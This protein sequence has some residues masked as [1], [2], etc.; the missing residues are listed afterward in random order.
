MARTEGDYL[1]A[2]SFYE[3]SLAIRRELGDER[4]I[5]VSLHNLGFVATYRGD[6]RQAAAFFEESL[7][8]FQKL[9]SKRGIFC[10]LEG[11]AGVAGGKGQSERAGRLIGAVE[12]LY[13]AFH[14]RLDYVDQIQ[15][16]RNVAAVRAQLDEATFAAVW[17]EGRAM[18]L[19]QAVDYA[20]AD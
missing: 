4:G 17:A 7:P 1:E 19:E 16:D 18:T 3:E 12:A 20:L 6:Y 8:L 9:G 14:M 10:S 15:H 2:R 13:A 5:G 11:L